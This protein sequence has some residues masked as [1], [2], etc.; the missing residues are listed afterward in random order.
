MTRHATLGDASSSLL[1]RRLDE[2]E[3]DNEDE[4]EDE[5]DDVE[6]EEEEDS[7]ACADA[8]STDA[9]CVTIMV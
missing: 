8:A 7:E 9:P 3:E 4:D 2:A 5:D 1:P 6:E